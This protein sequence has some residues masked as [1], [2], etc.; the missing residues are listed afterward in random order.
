MAVV[1]D[2]DGGVDAAGGDEVDRGAVGF[3]GHDFD[4][5]ERLE[6]V[7]ELDVEGLGAV[8]AQE[9]AVLSGAELERQDAHADEVRAVDA[10][11]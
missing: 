2:F 10:L 4:G 1:L 11:E 7:V 8:E 6:I 5:L 9:V 3:G